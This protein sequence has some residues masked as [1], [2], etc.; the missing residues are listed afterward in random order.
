[1]QDEF[2]YIAIGLNQNNSGPCKTMEEAERWAAIYFI[3]NPSVGKI[4]IYVSKV[5][6]ERGPPR[7][8]ELYRS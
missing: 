8:R 6:V 2:H 4:F 5:V 1:M 3:S 7:T